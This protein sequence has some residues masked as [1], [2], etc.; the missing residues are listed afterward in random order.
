MSD[1]TERSPPTAVSQKRVLHVGCGHLTIAQMTPGFRDGT[2][3]EVRFD[4][5]PNVSPDIIGTI[6]DMGAVADASVDAIYSS[7]NIEHVETFQV[8]QTLKEFHRVLNNDGFAA[9]TC[10]DIESIASVIV[11][12][13][14]DE[15]LYVSTAGPIS[16]LDVIYGF[17]ADIAR[18]RHY[19]AH[20][21][22]FTRVTLQNRIQEAGFAS[23]IIA[24][25]PSQFDLWA[26]A[27]KSP[28]PEARLREMLQTYGLR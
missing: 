25:R 23:V 7:H 22:A 2:W 10:P 16:P 8:V 18:G 24:R 21:T 26:V 1:T 12:G 28:T 4:L 6:T 27:T 19:M 11:E 3:E 13:R 9:I 15:P 20:R 14:L 5:D 17:G